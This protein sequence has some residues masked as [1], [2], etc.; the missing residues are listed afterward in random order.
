MYDLFLFSCKATVAIY[1]LALLFL[2]LNQDQIVFARQT[3]AQNIVLQKGTSEIQFSHQGETLLGWFIQRENAPLLIYYGGNGEEV[4]SYMPLFENQKAYSVLML[5]YRGYGQ[6]TGSPSETHLVADALH[7]FDTIVQQ[8]KLDPKQQVFLMGRSLGSGIAVQVAAQRPI[9]AA[10][11]VTPYDTL[12]NVGARKYPIFPVKWLVR[13]RFDSLSHAPN[14]SV[15]AL[16]LSAQLDTLIPPDHAFSLQDA[17]AGSTERHVFV[18]AH[19]DDIC[20]QDRFWPMVEDFILKQGSKKQ[21]PSKDAK[22]IH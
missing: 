8:R 1:C 4:S 3:L 16:F 21:D 10:I 17:W 2:Y 19:H 14:I 6:S 22:N 5:N 9:V 11:L 15:P 12:S 18:G 20:L 7:V 13:H